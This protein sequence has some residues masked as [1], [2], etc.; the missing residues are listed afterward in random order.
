MHLYTDIKLHHMNMNDFGHSRYL[1]FVV[2][3]HSKLSVH[4][5]YAFFC[6]EMIKISVIKPIIFHHLF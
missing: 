1:Y 3:K 4:S 2:L 5:H 6:M